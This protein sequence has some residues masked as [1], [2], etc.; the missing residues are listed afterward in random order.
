MLRPSL[1]SMMASLLVGGLAGLAD[2]DELERVTQTLVAPPFLP[3]HEQRATGPP[4][5]IQVRLVIEEK[6]LA[7]APGASIWALTFNGSVPG[8]II[9]VHE[10]DSVELTL[11][12][13]ASSTLS[14]NIDFHA[15]TGALGGG[16]LTN[17][18]P[19]QQ[20]V[21]R[22]KATKPGVFVYHCAPGGLMVPLHVVSGMTGA[23]MVLPRDGLKN[24]QGKPVTYDRAYYIGEQDFYLPQDETGKY[25][26]Y[27]VPAA[28]FSDMTEVMRTLTPTHVVFNGSLGALTGD[29][30]LSATVGETVLLIHSQANRDSRPHLIGGHGDL[31]WNG[32]SFADPPAQNL[33]TWFVPG[34]TATAMLYTFKQPGLYAYLNHNLIE[35][36]LLGAAAHVQVAGEWNDDLMMQVEKP[37]PIREP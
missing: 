8:P 19:G 7:V 24:A 30:A 15:S 4:K 6:I 1:L 37:R 14:H 25:K 27:S 26:T 18:A 3:A 32:G 12:N 33:E 31:V 13:P 29:N 5:L 28:G 23:I 16:A 36:F 9:V 22:F 35:A 2:A 21:L 11:V 20:V 34:G 17:V 10:N